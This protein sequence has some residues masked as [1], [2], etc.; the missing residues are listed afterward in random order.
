MG[1]DPNH[2]VPIYEQIIE[3]I[4]GSIASGVF[5]RGENL[6]SI[7][8]LALELVVNPNTVQRAYQEMERLG[9]VRTRK[10]LGMF[11]ADNG[12]DLARTQSESRVKTIFTQGISVG[13][14]AKLSGTDL[15]SIFQS[16]MSHHVSTANQSSASLGEKSSTDGSQS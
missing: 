14:G 2:H 1:V 5:R 8:S 12:H 3:T 16:A 13:Q 9:L 10:G 4:C 15:E 7:R 6:P 11:V